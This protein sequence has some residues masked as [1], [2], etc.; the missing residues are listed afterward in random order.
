LET[1]GSA[2]IAQVGAEAA[3]KTAKKGTS[4]KTG[5][6]L[7]L[8][9]QKNYLAASQ[10]FYKKVTANPEDADSYYYMG[11]C[12]V[13]LKNFPQALQ[14][15][16]RAND[17]APDSPTGLASK[18]AQDRITGLMNPSTP[19]T[20]AAGGTSKA[21]ILGDKDDDAG[22]KDSKDSKDKKDPRLVAAEAQGAVKI[23]AA[24]KAAK[25]ILDDATTQCKP[26]KDEEE[27][28]VSEAAANQPRLTGTETGN[29]IANDIRGP[30]EERIKNV[31]EPAK[32]KAQALRDAAQK[33]ADA[34]K[35]AV[36]L[37]K[38]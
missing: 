37:S 28:A 19:A 27:S 9:A 5:D 6:A 36:A 26:I 23:A 38:K 3:S 21:K 4:T 13:A 17:I 32:K 31:M 18:Q 7:S 24:D 20:A 14:Y 12:A 10:A 2:L 30:Y 1:I 8:Y 25:K 34:I 15:Y 33:E 16:K 29:Q 22:D 11:N 35:A